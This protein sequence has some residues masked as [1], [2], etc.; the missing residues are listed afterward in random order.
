MYH[1]NISVGQINQTD[2]KANFSLTLYQII[3]LNPTQTYK[4]KRIAIQKWAQYIYCKKK[5][6][7][8]YFKQ[9][10]N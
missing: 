2:V 4:R 8:V 3:S 6:L 10:L 7:F 9:M 1:I 5:L